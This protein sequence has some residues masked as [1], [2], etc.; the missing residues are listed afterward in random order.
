MNSFETLSDQLREALKKSP[1]LQ[2]IPIGPAFPP[3]RRPFPLRNPYICVHI[4]EITVE[5]GGLGGIV[6][7]NQAGTALGQ[8]CTLLF[9]LDI[10]CPLS[11]GADG[12][13]EIFSRLCHAIFCEDAFPFKA[14]RLE[15][16]SPVYSRENDCFVQ[17][18]VL[19]T[20]VLMTREEEGLAITDFTVR[21][22]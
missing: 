8:T 11:L 13:Q 4:K 14:I 5:Q 22:A 16:S 9:S 20:I 1:S 21:R 10:L 2:K 7:V 17:K 19:R 12:C 15:A 3:E 18:S 6:P